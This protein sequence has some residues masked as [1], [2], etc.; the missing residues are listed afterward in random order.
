MER[1]DAIIAGGGP[2]GATAAILLAQAGWSVAVVEK[3]RYPRRK[4]CGECIAAS[5]FAILDALGVGGEV[6]A[7]A[8]PELRHVVLCAGEETLAAELPAMHG[9]PHAW[10]RALGRETL[11]TLLLGRASR[12]GATV[13]QPV[14]LRDVAG[15]AGNYRC[16]VAMPDGAAATLA[17]PVLIVAHGSWESC[18]SR[19]GRRAPRGADLFA[20][21]A[22]FAAS[23]LCGGLLPVL[24]FRGGYGGM[25]VADGGLLTLAC[26]IRRDILRQLR[27]R[28]PGVSAGEV[29]AAYLREN[30]RAAQEALAGAARQGA[31]LSAGP[32]RP[33]IRKPWRPDGAFV[34]GNAAGEAHPLL[35]EGISMAL[36]SSWLL[37][38]QLIPHR[39]DLM[40][41]HSAFANESVGSI[42]RS[43]WHHAFAPRVWVAA[44]LAH[45]AMRPG[46][47]R[48]IAPLLRRWPQL[49][50]ASARL[51]GKVQCT[52]GPYAAH[53]F[54]TTRNGLA[55]GPR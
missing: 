41:S 8:G 54:A 29:V 19:D 26:C 51:G 33:G 28:M 15:R 16:R 5:N 31:W 21:K 24:A 38:E 52:V 9:G 46:V 10:G 49:V 4:V 25:V 53:I 45:A 1:Y 30:C 3:Q 14:S 18:A 44:V 39:A 50:G 20:F 6:A 11:D 34:V 42:Y 22:N 37:C 23:R 13:W 40:G 7:V 32:I 2:A 17:A 35:G 43:R 12:L 27:L 36:Q 48:V 55:R 47:V